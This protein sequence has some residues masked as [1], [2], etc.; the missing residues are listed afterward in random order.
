MPGSTH[1]TKTRHPGRP[2]S[3]SGTQVP[4]QGGCPWVPALRFAAAGMTELL[5][6][7][8]SA[9]ADRPLQA[10]EKARRPSPGRRRLPTVEVQA[11][12]GV[13]QRAGEDDSFVGELCM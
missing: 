1:P 4:V 11:Q 3:R 5:I 8:G 7:P 9:Q 10:S 13:G 12:L 6:E 2:K